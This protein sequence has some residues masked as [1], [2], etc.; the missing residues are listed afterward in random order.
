VERSTCWKLKQITHLKKLKSLR[1]RLR[2]RIINLGIFL[3]QS[4]QSS[5]TPK[6]SGSIGT[7]KVNAQS[8]MTGKSSGAI[9]K[10]WSYKVANR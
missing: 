4:S 5:I 6:V 3:S 1:F 8:L 2:M 9:E 7:T 10:S